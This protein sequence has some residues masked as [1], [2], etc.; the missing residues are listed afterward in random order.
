[1]EKNGEW[2]GKGGDR[3]RSHHRRGGGGEGEAED[4]REVISKECAVERKMKGG[5][6]AE[7]T[8]TIIM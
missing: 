8:M 4:I 6:E 7:L 5:Q 3:R 2:K 1:V